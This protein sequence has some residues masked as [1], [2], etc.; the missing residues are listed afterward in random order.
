MI[1][2]DLPEKLKNNVY[3]KVA[4][5]S[6]YWESFKKQRQELGAGAFLMTKELLLPLRFS[7]ELGCSF[8]NSAAPGAPLETLGPLGHLGPL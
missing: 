6:K 2:F 1:F 7:R 8:A 4:H 5:L 3:L